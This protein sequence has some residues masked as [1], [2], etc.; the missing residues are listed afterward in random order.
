MAFGCPLP[1]I[2]LG[3]QDATQG[4]HHNSYTNSFDST[5]ETLYEGKGSSNGS[6]RSH[7]GKSRLSRKPW[8]LKRKNVG[9]NGT[10]ERNDRKRAK[11]YRKRSLQGSEHRDP[12]RQAPVL[13]QSLK[14]TVPSSV[15]SRTHKY[16]RN[17]FNP[18]KGPETISGPSHQQ[19]MRKFSPTKEES[20]RRAKVQSDKAR[21]TRTAGSK[22]HSAAEGRP[23]RSRKTTTE[24]PCPYYLRSHFK[25]PEGIPQEQRSTGIDSLP[26]NSL[27]RRSLCMEALDGDPADRST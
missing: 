5:N 16:R 2:N 26:E 3:V 7:P 17:I 15:F 21:E 9:S 12:K 8:R 18:S 27:R 11:I 25:E 6:S 1:Q 24:R 10:A 23:V 22:G 20:R 19:Q 4:G 14:R 13:P